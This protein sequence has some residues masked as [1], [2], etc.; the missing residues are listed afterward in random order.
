MSGAAVRWEAL[1]LDVEVT[2]ATRSYE[3]LELFLF[4]AAGW[5]PHRIH[6]DLPYAT[7]VEGHDAV[8]VH[9]PLQAV[10]AVDALLD[11]LDVEV[12]VRRLAYRHR[13]LLTVGQEA[14]VR[15]CARER[16]AEGATATF[17]VWM[18][19]ARDGAPTTTVTATL[20]RSAR[21]SGH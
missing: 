8:V 17:D 19:R 16:E 18:A 11:A 15:A 21:P 6:Y 4:R 9:G 10:H 14:V 12:V 13:A 2:L 7:V 3:P 20:A 5:H 1:A